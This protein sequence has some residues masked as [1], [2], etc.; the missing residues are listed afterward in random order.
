M[1]AQQ[2]IKITI[3]KLQIQLLY[4]KTSFQYESY[5]NFNNNFRVRV[6]NDKEV[7]RNIKRL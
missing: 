7:E 2:I 3:I 4:N 5:Y 1:T 6:E